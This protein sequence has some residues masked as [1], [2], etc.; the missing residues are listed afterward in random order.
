MKLYIRRNEK[1]LGP[2]PIDQLK[3]LLEEGKLVRNDQASKDKI[4]WLDLGQ[5]L[6]AKNNETSISEPPSIEDLCRDSREIVSA[7]S[8]PVSESAPEK[9]ESIAPKQKKSSRSSENIVSLFLNWI[10]ESLYFFLVCFF[11]EPFVIITK[12]FSLLLRYY[13]AQKEF[14]TT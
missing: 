10:S 3:Q 7:K 5:F 11:F 13:L 6:D 2:Y 4:V 1:D 12:C 9:S 8:K 14:D